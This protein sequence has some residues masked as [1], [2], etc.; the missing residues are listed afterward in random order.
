MGKHEDSDTNILIAIHEPDMTNIYLA[1]QI[2]DLDISWPF[3]A[4]RSAMILSQLAGSKGLQRWWSILWQDDR[5]WWTP[6]AD[7]KG[8]DEGMME[9]WMKTSAIC[10]IYIIYIYILLYF[11]IYMHYIAFYISLYI[12]LRTSA[13]LICSRWRFFSEGSRPR[14]PIAIHIAAIINYTCYQYF[15]RTRYSSSLAF[16][17]GFVKLWFSL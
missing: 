5:G 16:N 12:N 4:Q 13:G 17:G 8:M 14:P 11:N 10:N 15:L 2:L 7:S 1:W 9:R 3:P 6:P